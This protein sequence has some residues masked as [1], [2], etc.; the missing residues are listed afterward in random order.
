MKVRFKN[1]IL[2]YSGKVDNL[3]FYWNN[4][5]G[6]TVCREYVR[7]EP[8][9]QHARFGAIARNLQALDISPG[10][11]QDLK[12]YVDLWN[13]RSRNVDKPYAN[14]L[15][16]FY[17]IMYALARSNP[18]IDLATLTRDEIYNNSYPCI[19]VSEAIEADLIPEFSGYQNLT[20]QM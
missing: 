10:Y 20:A 15:N 13:T 11:I 2:S 17:K 8:T 1:N 12:V 4:R 19:S 16:V 9:A 5:L 3:V 7:P 6:R 18:A 14:W